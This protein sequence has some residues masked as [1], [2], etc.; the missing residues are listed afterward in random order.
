MFTLNNN[1]KQA[2]HAPDCTAPGNGRITGS[3]KTLGRRPVVGTAIL[4]VLLAGQTA[5]AQAQSTTASQDAWTVLMARPE[6][7]DAVEIFK[8]AG[9]T[10]YVATDKFTAFIPTN[11]AFEK[12]PTVLPQLLRDRSRAF[13]DTTVAV[14]FIRSHAIYDMHPL[15]EFAGKQQTLT[16]I[17][18]LPITIDGRNAGSFKVS[19]V[20]VQSDTATAYVVD[21]PIVTANGVIYPIDNVVLT[22]AE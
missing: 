8:Y 4:G 21:K 1:F 7:S 9:L 5:T 10:Q 6:F 14:Q 17:S 3:A 16:A 2:A 11:A 22:K 19:W 18:G 15:S 13:P 20:S 12:N